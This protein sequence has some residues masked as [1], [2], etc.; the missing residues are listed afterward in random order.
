LRWLIGVAAR[1][2]QEAALRLI[3]RDGRERLGLRLADPAGRGEVAAEIGLPARAHTE[4]IEEPC[5]RATLEQGRLAPRR[6]HAAAGGYIGR[7]PIFA[8][9]ERA[10]EDSPNLDRLRIEVARERQRI[11]GQRPAL[12]GPA[13]VLGRKGVSPRLKRPPAAAG[14]ILGGVG[15]PH[16]LV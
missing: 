11:R 5:A 6:L 16:R 14:L 9:G 15:L 2:K 4:A 12:R 10:F 3:D 8:L 7:P 13:V 1:G